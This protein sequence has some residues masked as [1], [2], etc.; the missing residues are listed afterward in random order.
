[1]S[2]PTSVPVSTDRLVIVDPANLGPEGERTAL[3]LVAQGA[4]V[5]VSVPGDGRYP[6]ACHPDGLIVRPPHWW[7][8]WPVMAFHPVS[9]DDYST[10]WAALT[11]P[12]PGPA[13]VADFTAERAARR[14]LIHGRALLGPRTHRPTPKPT[15]PAGPAGTDERPPA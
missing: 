9:G 2:R 7:I 3:A 11:D 14:R 8:E 1:M 6:V 4:A 10:W 13:P 5:L 12:T 15:L